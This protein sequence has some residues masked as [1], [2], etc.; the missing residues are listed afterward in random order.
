MFV[1]P[2]QKLIKVF[3]YVQQNSKK[4]FTF[5][6]IR[7]IIAYVMINDNKTPDSPVGES[8]QMLSYLDLI[9][10]V[11]LSFVKTIFIERR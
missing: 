2:L 8:L 7:L 6:N 9:V 10:N 5:V 1:S 3:V 4:V 11:L